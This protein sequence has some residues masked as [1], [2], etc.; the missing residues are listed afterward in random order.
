MWYNNK[1]GHWRQRIIISKA[2]DHANDRQVG[3]DQSKSSEVVKALLKDQDVEAKLYDEN[4]VKY[5]WCLSVSELRELQM[6]ELLWQKLLYRQILIVNAFVSTLWYSHVHVQL[7]TIAWVV[8]YSLITSSTLST[9]ELV[10]KMRDQAPTA[11]LEEIRD[12][13]NTSK[14]LRKVLTVKYIL[15]NVKTW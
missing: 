5:I 10:L 4:W 6:L 13:K 12:L 11:A 3:Q 15:N 7:Y 2:I 14:M 1:S 8:H 9:F